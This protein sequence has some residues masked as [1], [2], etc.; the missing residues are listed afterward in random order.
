[1]LAIQHEITTDQLSQLQQ[2]ST[3]GDAA[4]GADALAASAG[5]RLLGDSKRSLLATVACVGKG[6]AGKSSMN[7]NLAVTAQMAGFR[8]AIVD[9]DPQKSVFEWRRMRGNSDIPVRRCSPDQ[10]PE[11][12]AAAKRSGVQ[13]LFIDMPP[14]SRFALAA[15]RCS[16]LIL[17]PMRPTLFDLKVTQGLIQLLQSAGADYAVV[18]NAAP[19]LRREGDSPMVRE[20][21]D[22]LAGIG[23]QLWRRQ[24]THRLAVPYAVIGGAGVIETEPD[25]FAAKEYGAL[26]QAIY[27][28]LKPERNHQ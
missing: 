14:D 20:T 23:A 24:I 6:G 1:M 15:A 26:W 21:R 11:A 12:V 27:K 25:G 5:G 3:G 22:A 13:L 17:I 7:I 19:P 18:I 2:E 8:V 28:K 16:D 4:P 9:A 10:L